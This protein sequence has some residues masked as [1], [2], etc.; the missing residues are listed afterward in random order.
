MS[1]ENTGPFRGEIITFSSRRTAFVLATTAAVF[2]GLAMVS[3]GSAGAVEGG[4]VPASA[5]TTT[6][7]ATAGDG[8]SVY[9]TS[10]AKDGTRV[11]TI[12]DPAPGV[13]PA[14]LAASL[15]A[16][17]IAAKAVAPT[18]PGTAK[19][20]CSYGSARTWGCPMAR[21]P[22][23]SNGG[24]A[25][26]FL[27]HTSRAWPVQTAASYWDRTR[28]LSVNYRW[29]SRGCPPASVGGCVKVRSA[30]YGATGWTG[31][32]S[33][34]VTSSNVIAYAATKLN[35]YYRGSPAEHRNTACHEMGHVLGLDHN[36]SSSSCLYAART[37]V[38]VPN[39][40]DFSLLEIY[41]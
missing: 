6:T 35:D 14:N 8:G 25:V 5:A 29:Y 38:Q 17:G 24:R 41:Y 20:A 4:S 23:N 21:W 16:T 39:S 3:A 37:S 32:T 31:Q 28:G 34:S 2:A 12:Y 1:P 10:K 15:R 33:R 40:N 18:Q 11:D 7:T 22:V 19:A 9:A 27:D 36:H 26:Y 30:N 13:T